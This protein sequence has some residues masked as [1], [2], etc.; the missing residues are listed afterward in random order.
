M[1]GTDL[2][3][4][5]D[6]G[7]TKSAV[8]IGDGSGRVLDR[9]QW[10][11]EATRGPEAII[12]QITEQANSLL[13]RYANVCAA[14]VAIGGP[15]DAERGIVYSPPNLPGWESVALRDRL[16]AAFQMP[17]HVEHD[18]A[19]CCLAEVRWGAGREARRVVYLTCGTG[20]GA[21]IVIDGKI[22]RGTNGRNGE[23]GHIQYRDD[24]PMAFGKKGSA[25]AFCAGSQLGALAAWMFP[26]RFDVHSTTGPRLSALASE[27]D[28]AAQAVLN[29][30][31][32]AVGDMCALL[33]DLLV[34][35]VIIIGSLA[36]Y[37]DDGWLH[38][39]RQRFASQVLESVVSHCRIV[40][41]QL[42]E[43]LQDASAL[44]AALPAWS[45]N[46]GGRQ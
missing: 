29:Q 34:P 45:C 26:D 33:G 38:R 9:R 14:G 40:P 1:T 19:A 27:G 28:Q 5:I 17:V 32:Q 21:G 7:G 15:I 31:A 43:R 3:L 2:I 4:G 13:A 41:S 11:T 16:H 8:L 18:G 20:F 30:N 6:I 39:V 24:G 23:I 36:R 37:L 22:D 46:F 42:G 35:D 25:E 10:P 12:A 44:A